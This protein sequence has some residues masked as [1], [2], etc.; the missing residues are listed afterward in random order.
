MKH[1]DER[2]RCLLHPREHVRSFLRYRTCATHYGVSPSTHRLE[3][4]FGARK[5]HSIS[6]MAFCLA[7]LVS[8]LFS[9]NFSLLECGSL[10]PFSNP[11]IPI[12][13]DT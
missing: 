3:R 8:G 12:E 2:L 6:A 11:I 7:A 9:P 10:G 4:S 1:P 5:N 13:V